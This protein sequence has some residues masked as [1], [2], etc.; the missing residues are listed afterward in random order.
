MIGTIALL[1]SVPLLIVVSYGVG[2]SAACEWQ[3]RRGRWM[4]RFWLA[5][6]TPRARVIVSHYLRWRRAWGIAGYARGIA[7][8]ER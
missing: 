1:V 5:R 4:L 8:G 7:W 2:R 3:Y 6:R